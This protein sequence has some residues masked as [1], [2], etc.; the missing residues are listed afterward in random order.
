MGI[1]MGMYIKDNHVYAP[2]MSRDEYFQGT[3]MLVVSRY[4]LA[5]E[6][7]YIMKT[8]LCALIFL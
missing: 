4:A 6:I 1:D 3:E 7:P 2:I 8:G 5:S